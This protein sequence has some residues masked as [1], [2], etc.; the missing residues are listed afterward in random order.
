MTTRVIETKYSRGF[1]ALGGHLLNAPYYVKSRKAWYL[2]VV[3]E[4]GKR[5]QIRI[6]KNRTEAK[7]NWEK[8]VAQEK[9]RE[10]RGPSVEEVIT[11]YA[12][13]AEREVG[14]GVLKQKTLDGYVWY[15][16]RFIVAH[17]DLAA[18]DVAPHHVT[19]WITS[20]DGWGASA[21]RAA[22]AALKRAFNWAA[23]DRRILANPIAT[24]RRPASNR[25]THLIN[26]ADH[27][28]LVKKTGNH[29]YAGKIDR[30]FRLALVAI[31]QCGGRPQDVANARV[32]YVNE[33]ITTWTLPEHKTKRKTQ[34]PRTIYLSPCLQTITRIL[35]AGRTEGPLFRGRRGALTVNAMTCR[36]KRLRRDLGL[37]E[38]TVTYAYRHSYI[39]DAMYR[40]VDVATV[41]T[42]TGT[43]VEMIQRHYGHL[44]QRSDHLQKAA[45]RAVTAKASQRPEA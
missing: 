4:D 16:S 21:E 33:E 24:M 26:D 10:D 6:G 20:F 8:R 3:G 22:I 41:A 44:S 1:P 32:E 27:A 31:R 25:R 18:M 23:G 9:Q 19:D 37:A 28:S 36:L 17:G 39:T 5:S 2:K 29:A 11:D 30:Q 45:I 38:G 7:Q 42:L 13:W 40:G 14:K 35:I 43:S 15:L 34:Q 12:S